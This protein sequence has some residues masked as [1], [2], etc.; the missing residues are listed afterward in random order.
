MRTPNL[1]PLHPQWRS[2]SPDRLT[3]SDEAAAVVVGTST[4]A[5]QPDTSPPLVR[6]STRNVQISRNG[7]LEVLGL[8][9]LA[10]AYN[11]VRALP[12]N[13]SPTA[14][15][16]ARDVLSWEGPLFGHLEVPLNTWLQGST[17]LAVAACYSYAVVHY[18]ATPIVFF[19]SRRR[20][21]WQYWRGYWSLVI[22]SGIA[23]VVY[24]LYPVAPPRMMPDLGITDV[25]R[26]YAGYGWWGDAASAPRGIGDATNQ[27]AA[28]PSM[29]FGWALWCSIQMWGFGSR[30]LRV[31]AVAYP[32]MLTVVV[33]GTGNHFLLDVVGGAACVVAAYAVVQTLGRR[34]N[35]PNHKHHQ[36]AFKPQGPWRIPAHS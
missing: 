15:A 5:G 17:V 23:L 22:A 1:P 33:L 31:L 25:M 6:P 24:A 19:M 27:F 12:E 36:R 34:C 3:V 32:A 18:A 13:S 10:V 30:P 29:H 4:A 20:G 8:L 14:F 11:V 21:G 26:S 9:V 16:H 35:Q 2:T 7:I 28:M